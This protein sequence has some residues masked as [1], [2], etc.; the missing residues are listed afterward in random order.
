AA[1]LA[2]ARDG[3]LFYATA[4]RAPRPPGATVWARAIDEATGAPKGDAER[5]TFRAGPDVAALSISDDGA[6]VALLAFEFQA[7]VF[8]GSLRDGGKKLDEPV[9]LT[10]DQRQ[11]RPSGW[12]RDSRE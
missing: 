3:R 11:D 9:R 2:W 5:V 12:T 8:V 7:D 1:A 4:E 10:L 6:R